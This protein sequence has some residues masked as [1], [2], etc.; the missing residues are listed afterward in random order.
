MTKTQK[1][2][3]ASIRLSRIYGPVGSVRLGGSLPLFTIPLPRNSLP[4]NSKTAGSLYTK[5][6]YAFRI[7]RQRHMRGLLSF[8]AWS[9]R[10]GVH[11]PFLSA[12]DN[13]Y[14]DP[15]GPIPTSGWSCVSAWL[16]YDEPPKRKGAIF[17][18]YT[19]HTIFQ[20]QIS[21]SNV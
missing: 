10:L 18:V 4:V 14:V 17:L 19:G 16:Y 20:I 15:Q 7:L 6:T 3:A 21:C 11:S 8:N 13:N 5:L 1:E 12:I 2:A 9:Q